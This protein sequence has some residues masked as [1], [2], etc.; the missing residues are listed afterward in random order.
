MII[1]ECDR[2]IQQQNFSLNL[3][4]VLLKAKW[5]KKMFEWDYLMYGKEQKYLQVW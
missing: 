1:A 4:V 2:C 3:D 5:D